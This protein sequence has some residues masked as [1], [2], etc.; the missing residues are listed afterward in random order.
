ME[1]RDAD[2][3]APAGEALARR[4]YA[5]VNLRL[6]VF[7]R[8]EAGYHGLETIFLRSALHDLVEVSNGP[9][10]IR[11]FVEGDRDPEVPEGSSNLC[12]RAAERFFEAVGEVPAVSIRL[13]KRIPAA[14]GLGGGSADGAA[15]LRLLAAQMPHRL[16][17]AA[18]FRVAGRLGSDLPFALLDVP[19]ALGWERGRRLLPLRPPPPR[20]GLILLPPFRVATP[21]AF[22]WLDEDRRAGGRGKGRFDPDADGVAG[23]LPGPGRL[24]D[25][26]VLARLARSDFEWTVFGRHPMLEERRD[27]LRAAGATIALLSGSGP[28]LFA[29][30]VDA[31]Q[32][33]AAADPALE[34]D[35]WRLFRTDLPPDPRGS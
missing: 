32:R 27:A 12:W 22:G 7:G 13:V 15:V 26:Q 17:E 16:S 11:L 29:I 14:A 1:G 19:M 4:A 34:V 9:P 6:R 2:P 23:A 5:K 8:D 31:R 3:G 18:L 24:H 28:A 25:W 33:D 20:P 21:E 35:G 10:G 30:F